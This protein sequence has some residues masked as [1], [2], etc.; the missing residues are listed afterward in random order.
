[1][2]REIKDQNDINELMNMVCYFHDSCIKE[3]QYVSG[4]YVQSD[5][6]AMYPLN[7]KRV[8][9]VMIQS[10]LK[11]VRDVELEFS[12]LVYLKLFPVDEKY[13]CEILGASIF[14]KDDCFIFCENEDI[15]LED[16]E[17]Y[18]GTVICAKKLRW[19]CSSE[20]FLENKGEN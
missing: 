12:E 8:L 18:E 4:A 19:H 16:I 9:R 17:D 10:Q 20:R 1:M 6:L 11:H 7:D 15:S 3:M 13:T 5:D 14:L 2:F